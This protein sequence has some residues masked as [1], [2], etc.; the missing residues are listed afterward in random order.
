MARLP[1]FIVLGFALLTNSC[2]TVSV[3]TKEV[4]LRPSERIIVSGG[5]I[6]IRV[7]NGGPGV[8]QITELDD[9]A[10]PI[11]SVRSLDE[12]T[13]I[14][15]SDAWRHIELANRSNETAAL[16]LV[17]A[18]EHGVHVSLQYERKGAAKVRRVQ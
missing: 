7:I 17:I 6:S 9:N 14:L 8:I 5:D 4:Q 3:A 16:R 11:G 10:R 13:T 18:S 12:G 15:R 1:L 2:A